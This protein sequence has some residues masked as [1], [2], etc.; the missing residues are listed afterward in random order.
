MYLVLSK[1]ERIKLALNLRVELAIFHLFTLFSVYFLP[2]S[3]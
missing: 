1:E 3:M 2:K